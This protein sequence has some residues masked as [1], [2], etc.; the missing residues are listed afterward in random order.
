MAIFAVFNASSMNYDS[1][2]E[3]TICENC[4]EQGTYTVNK[5][6]PQCGEYNHKPK[7]VVVRNV[8]AGSYFKP[9]TW[10]DS[11]QEFKKAISEK[12]L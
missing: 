11:K 3:Q 7:I 10:F 5:L 12:D 8:W 1:W 6:C 4:G 9:W 2:Y